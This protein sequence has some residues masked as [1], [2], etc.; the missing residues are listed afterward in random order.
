LN[1]LTE[2]EVLALGKID[3]LL[4]PADDLRAAQSLV[5]DLVPRV[6]IPFGANAAELC[7]ALGVPGATLESRF[8]WNGTAATPR[9]V[10]LKP[11][12][13]RRRAA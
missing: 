10:L 3:V 2:R 6:V 9:A 7:A 13:A 4:L 11:V 1:E 8:A 5:T 12:A